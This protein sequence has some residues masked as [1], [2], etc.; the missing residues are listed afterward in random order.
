MYATEIIAELKRLI[1]IHGDVPVKT[2]IVNGE[3]FTKA[4]AEVTDIRYTSS[5]AWRKPII[6]IVSK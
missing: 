3:S 2:L 5:E 1:E 6:K 4:E